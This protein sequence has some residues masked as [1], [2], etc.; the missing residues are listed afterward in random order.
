[1]SGDDNQLTFMQAGGQ[2]VE[3]LETCAKAANALA[4]IEEDVD[5]AFELADNLLGAEERIASTRF[6]EF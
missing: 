5:A 6:A 2:L 4:G 3:L 1:M